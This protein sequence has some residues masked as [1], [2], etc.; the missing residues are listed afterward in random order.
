LLGIGF[1]VLI[2][3]SAGTAWLVRHAAGDA[4]LVNQTVVVQDKLANVLLSVRRAES[5]QR[6]YLFTERPVYLEDFSDSEPLAARLLDELRGLVTDNP[7][8]QREVEQIATNVAAK[9]TEMKRV[10]G[11]LNAGERDRARVEVLAGEGRRLMNTVREQIEAAIV[12]EG[13][14]LDQRTIRSQRT[15]QLLL[16]M[17]LLGAAFIIFIGAIS[18]SLVQ[19]NAR[20]AD[21]ARRELEGTNNNLE[22]IVEFRTAD[23]TEANNEIQRFA[24]I[25]SHDLRSP[26]VN[27]MGFTSELEAL[28]KDIFDEIARLTAA[29]SALNGQAEAAAG[30]VERLGTDFD[31]A[32]RFIKTSIGNM[33]R[34][35]NAVLKLSR[36]G[37]R[38]FH[39]Q[40]IDVKAL[41]EQISQTVSHRV[42]ELGANLA[43]E[44]LPRVESD[45]LALEQIFANLIDNALKYRR[46]EDTLHIR[47][48]GRATATHAVYDVV[49]N[50]RGIDASDHQRVF[51]LFRRSGRHYRPGE[52]I[53]LAH[54]RAL[55]RPIGRHDRIE[56][57]VGTRKHVHRQPAAT[58]VGECEDRD[59]NS[60]LSERPVEIV[61]IEDDEGHARLIEKNMR[62]A[63][64]NNRI[65]PF[66]SGSDAV[67]YLFG[68][69]GSGLSNKA[70]PLLILLDLNLPDITGVEILS[71]IKTNE[72]LKRV[73][74]V[75][76]TTTDDAIEIQ[77]CYDLGCNIY[78]TKPVNYES[79]ANAIRQLGLF[80][81]VIQ[82]PAP[83]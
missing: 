74:V 73:P 18:I 15:N 66:S 5:G 2:A 79:F 21:I 53:G 35:I 72:H 51:E 64:I 70:R 27:I 7:T 31:E 22:R 37:R 30:K 82:V 13:R 76:L 23:L 14:L 16:M 54:V 29:V 19:R 44:D 83:D 49:D 65:T 69:N 62:R 20:Q 45:P 59:M 4:Q 41:L 50:G 17:T 40:T 34:L 48:R 81:S 9:F 58:V 39:P 57:R 71:R 32:L 80:F 11:I 63:G 77:H 43:V 60:Q 36:E 38:Q 61:M 6:G 46:P 1:T 28:R 55:V 68:A 25:V 47:L 8:R 67:N 56:I 75:V 42:M 26:L 24:Y 52:G 12:D 3:M 33:D 78:V 10:L